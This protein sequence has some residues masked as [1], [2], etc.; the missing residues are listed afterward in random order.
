MP[1]DYSAIDNAPLPAQS[2]TAQAK[3]V[4]K[5]KGLNPLL[6]LGPVA[7]QGFDAATTLSAMGPGTKEGNPLMEPFADNP[8][9]LLGTKGAVGL[10]VGLGANQLAKS[11]HRK[12]GKIMAAL[13]TAIPAAVGVSNLTKKK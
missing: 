5:R 12:A 13:G 9:A 7:G 2:R 6:V 4:E 8:A 1:L 3:A 11:G 10:L